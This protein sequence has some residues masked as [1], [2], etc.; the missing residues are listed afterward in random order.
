MVLPHEI[1][2][3]GFPR[4]VMMHTAQQLVQNAFAQGTARC[5]HLIY[6]Q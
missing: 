4:V 6:I 5:D 2:D 1:I 3:C